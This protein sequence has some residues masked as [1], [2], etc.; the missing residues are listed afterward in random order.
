MKYIS[1]DGRWKIS[2]C[3][4]TKRSNHMRKS[5]PASN[6]KYCYISWNK[7][8]ICIICHLSEIKGKPYE[9]MTMG[10]KQSYRIFN[11]ENVV[12]GFDQARRTKFEGNM[13]NVQSGSVI[14]FHFV[15]QII[16]TQCKQ[17]RQIIHIS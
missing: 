2:K 13:N 17:S 5:F 3:D 10:L 15:Q 9:G 4:I 11:T 14:G 12:V 6:H 8:K 7:A 1:Y 16:L